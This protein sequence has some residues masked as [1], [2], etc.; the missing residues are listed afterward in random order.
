MNK[1]IFETE[2]AIK[3]ITWLKLFQNDDKL[4]DVKIGQ[5]IIY[6]NTLLEL[7]CK[8]ASNHERSNELYFGFGWEYK[9]GLEQVL[10]LDF[11]KLKDSV[12]WQGCSSNSVVDGVVL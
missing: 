2:V 7:K 4:S 6:L 10:A 12:E 9:L 3:H 8:I 5:F 1:Y 11:D